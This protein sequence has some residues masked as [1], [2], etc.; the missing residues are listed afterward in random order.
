VDNSS[1]THFVTLLLANLTGIFTLIAV[2]WRAVVRLGTRFEAVETGL[3][4]VKKEQHK[5]KKKIRRMQQL[6]SVEV[7]HQVLERERV[8]KRDKVK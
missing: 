5:Q 8:Q 3:Q 4:E 6:A 1:N 2:I 7:R